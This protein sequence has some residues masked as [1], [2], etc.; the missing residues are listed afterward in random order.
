[1]IKQKSGSI[2]SISGTA[3]KEGMALRG[4]YALAKW[5]LLGLTQTSCQRSRPSRYKSQHRLSRRHG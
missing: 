2:V 4:L 3:G 1:M 5:G